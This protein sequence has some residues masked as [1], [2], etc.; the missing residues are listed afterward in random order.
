VA[1]NDPLS[2][3]PID[4]ARR[5]WDAH[6]WEA[7]SAMVATTSIM[8]AHQ[9]VQ[10]AVD[11]AL[12]PF[13]LTFARYEALVLISFSRAGELPLG[14]MGD[15]LM[16]HPASVTNA[17]DRLERQGLVVRKRSA[18]DR[19]TVLAVITDDGRRVVDEATAAL[20]RVEY[21]AG[22]LSETRRRELYEIIR[23]LR[24]SEGDFESS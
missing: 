19:R 17:I 9:I 20:A 1:R 18:T 14:K 23:D 13:D 6:G 7:S 10:R 22:A 2:F 16:V 12:A 3:D 5:Q 24:Q 8:R 21:G 11:E 15:R 4:E